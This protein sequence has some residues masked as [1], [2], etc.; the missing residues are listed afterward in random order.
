MKVVIITPQA[1]AF[2]DVAKN[3][4]LPTEIGEITIQPNHMPLTT[5]IKP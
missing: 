1:K 3:I 5:I 4:S 2:D